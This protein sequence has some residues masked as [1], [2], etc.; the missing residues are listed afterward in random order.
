[1]GTLSGK[2][3]GEAVARLITLATLHMGSPGADMLLSADAGGLLIPILDALLPNDAIQDILGAPALLAAFLEAT[4]LPTDDN[5][6]YFGLLWDTDTSGM[7]APHLLNATPV[8]APFAVDV[9]R[10]ISGGP[11]VNEKPTI[12]LHQHSGDRFAERIIPYYG[13]I[14]VGSLTESGLA[15]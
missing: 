15:P 14:R 4:A 2:L 6:S 8:Q 7:P 1:M 9:N 11:G 3:G 10:H 13:E 5:E 12:W